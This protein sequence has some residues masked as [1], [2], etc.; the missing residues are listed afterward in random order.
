MAIEGLLRLLLTFCYG[1]VTG[2]TSISL[3]FYRD[4]TG[5]TAQREGKRG[6]SCFDT[7]CIHTL[8]RATVNPLHSTENSEEPC[9][10]SKLEHLCI[11]QKD[12]ALMS[13][14][15]KERKATMNSKCADQTRNQ[16]SAIRRALTCPHRFIGEAAPSQRLPSLAANSTQLHPAHSYLRQS[17]L[18][19]CLLVALNYRRY[20]GSSVLSDLAIQSFKARRDRR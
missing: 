1:F 11:G 20:F 17:L 9:N 15:Q 3:P 8:Q 13:R 19:C 7:L 6:I 10:P 5:V 14:S 4:V 16:T 18:Y 2:Q 12:R